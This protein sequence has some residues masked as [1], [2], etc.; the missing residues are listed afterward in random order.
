MTRETGTHAI[1]SYNRSAEPWNDRA[2]ERQEAL[3]CG[4]GRFEQP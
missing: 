4:P 3:M 1:E 2:Y